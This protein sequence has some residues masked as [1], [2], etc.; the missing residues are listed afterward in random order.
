MVI[1]EM[2]DAGLTPRNKPTVPAKVIRIDTS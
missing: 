1:I 2:F